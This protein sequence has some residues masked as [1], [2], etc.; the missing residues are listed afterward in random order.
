MPSIGLN[1][2]DVYGSVYRVIRLE[3]IYEILGVDVVGPDVD[4]RKDWLNVGLAHRVFGAAGGDEQ[5]EQA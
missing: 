1:Y 2:P 3:L 5:Y 4:D